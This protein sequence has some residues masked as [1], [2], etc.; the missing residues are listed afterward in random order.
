MSSKTTYQ[1]RSL[2]DL[3]KVPADRREA[4][5]QDILYS[6]A[7]HELVFGDQAFQNEIGEL[8]WCDDGRHDVEITDAA[9]DVVLSLKTGSV[10]S[11]STPPP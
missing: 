2:H 10:E 6:L 1:L 9:G 11:D 3:L 7:V 4:C 8:A 5:V